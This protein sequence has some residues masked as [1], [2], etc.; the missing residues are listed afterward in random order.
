M[1]NDSIDKV[2]M[3]DLKRKIFLR[4]ALI[5]IDGLQEIFDLNDQFSGDELLGEIFK[6]ALQNFEFYCPL[7]WESKVSKYQLRPS[8]RD[9]W[10]KLENNFHLYLEDSISED[11][12]ILVPNATPKIRSLGSYPEYPTAYYSYMP[13]AYQRPNIFLGDMIGSDQFYMRGL[14]NRPCIQDYTVDHAFS[15]RAAIYWM[16]IEEGVYG[17]KFLD[18]CMVDIL[19]YVRSLKANLQLPNFSVDIFGAVDTTYQTLKAEVD[20]FYLQSNWKGELLV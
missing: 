9:G 4:S 12:I 3:K 16:N 2:T 1:I 5:P 11:Q 15:D 8:G 14:C 7:V 18:Q 20:Q 10:Y 17:Q 6:K 19:D 13:V